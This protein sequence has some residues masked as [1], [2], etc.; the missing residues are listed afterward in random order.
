MGRGLGPLQQDILKALEGL[1]EEHG[2]MVR[3]VQPG[4]GRGTR[5]KMLK[6]ARRLR[7]RGLVEFVQ[8]WGTDSLGRAA[9]VVCVCPPGATVFSE[10]LGKD[11]PVSQLHVS[12]SDP[13]VGSGVNKIGKRLARQKAAV[14]IHLSPEEAVRD[15]LQT[16]PTVDKELSL[17][18]RIESL[19]A[20]LK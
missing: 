8:V 15:Y 11:S 7:D 5:S 2:P 20:R 14:G 10:E 9:L 17:D 6:A 16:E 1:W 18:E 19:Q 3:L 13:V 12:K 4:V